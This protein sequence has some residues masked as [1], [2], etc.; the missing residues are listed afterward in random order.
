MIQV[1]SISDLDDIAAGSKRI[2]GTPVAAKKI[3]KKYRNLAMK[4]AQK[5]NENDLADAETIQ[6]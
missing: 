3:I 5:N 2:S 4:K 1:T 6:K